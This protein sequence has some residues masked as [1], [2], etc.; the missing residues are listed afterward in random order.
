MFTIYKY[1]NI[2]NI[3][4]KSSIYIIFIIGVYEYNIYLL[5][6][7]KILLKL[8][9]KNNTKYKN[10]KCLGTDLQT[11]K[12]RLRKILR[13]ASIFHSFDNILKEGRGV[14]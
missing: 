3:Y 6:H 12:A 8:S 11:S 7:V 2:T 13:T 10:K 4:N 5:Y 9:K 14:Y 1:T